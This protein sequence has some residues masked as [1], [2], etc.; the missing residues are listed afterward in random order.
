MFWSPGPGSSLTGSG[1][2]FRAECRYRR[3]RSSHLEQTRWNSMMFGICACTNKT[4]A[5]ISGR[6]IEEM[7]RKLC[8]GPDSCQKTFWDKSSQ[9]APGGQEPSGRSR[10]GGWWLEAGRRWGT[11]PRQFRTTNKLWRSLEL[12]QHCKNT[13]VQALFGECP[14]VIYIQSTDF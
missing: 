3:V 11:S 5:E 1:S 8:S 9:R 14:T 4:R 10:A 12:G 13:S 2:R 7:L 6:T